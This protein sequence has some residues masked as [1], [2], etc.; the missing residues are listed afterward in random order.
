MLRFK[1]AA[2]CV[3]LLFSVAV[4]ADDLPEFDGGDVVVTASGIPQDSSALPV[5]V[6]VISAQDIADSSARSVQ[7]LLSEAGGVNVINMGGTAAQVDLHG[8]GVGGVSNTLILVD[9]VRQNSNDLA[10]PDLSYIPLDS[11]ERVEIVRGSGAVQY[12]SGATGGVINIITKA[13]YKAG[14]R[15]SLTET[16]GS[17]NLRQTDLAFRLAGD[18]FSIDGWGQSMNT[19]HYRDNNTERRDSGGMGLNWKLDDGKLRVYARSSSD[20]ERLPGGRTVDLSAGGADQFAQDPSGTSTPRDNGYVKTDEAG[21]QGD[22]GLGAGRLYYQLA[23]RDKR[24][25]SSWFGSGWSAFDSRQTNEN[26]GRLRYVLPFAGD[27]QWIAGTDWLYGDSTDSTGSVSLSSVQ[28]HASAKQRQQ[29]LFTELQLAPW[30]GGRITLGGRAQRADDRVQCVSG[31]CYT[32]AS[33]R[34]LHAWQM[35]L[36][37]AMG[38]GWS[39]FA[40]HAQS[41]RLP[42]ADELANTSSTLQ[43]QTSH[44]QQLGVEWTRA[45]SNVRADVFRSD[46]SNEISYVP[47][48]LWG[49]NTNLPRT[50]HEGLE[51]EGRTRLLPTVG[52][53]GNLTWQRATFREGNYNGT[54]V[55]GNTVPMVPKWMANLGL[56][57]DRTE[58]TRLSVEA[59]YIGKQ[60]LDND[61]TNQYGTQLPA[62][63]LVNAKVTHRFTRQL[64]GSLGVNNLFNRRYAT[65]G[66]T[67]TSSAYVVYPGDAR[68]VQASLTLTL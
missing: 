28:T 9:G 37:Q 35:G 10:A 55:A 2:A 17:F 67:S 6:S 33:T 65:Y 45:A 39:A 20:S 63:V 27:N 46:V 23:V 49:S 61:Q 15:L 58:Q 43:P 36:R 57:W 60:Y 1:C 34:M 11:I 64:S 7:E 40:N 24:T 42:N 44:D 31:G 38:S 22:Q 41:F 8:F 47:Y 18:R 50:R 32:Y 62:Y 26:N 59:N 30:T 48:P 4:R 51:L 16:L 5:S 12:G 21:V 66:Y 68:N 14:N 52:L 13:G 54:S 29:S 56:S 3:P 25:D 19:R 53:R